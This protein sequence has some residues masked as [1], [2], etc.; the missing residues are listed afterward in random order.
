MT[1]REKLLPAIGLTVFAALVLLVLS[2]YV[3]PAMLIE[4]ASLR[5]CS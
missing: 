2:A 3:N 5:L 1:L 4:L